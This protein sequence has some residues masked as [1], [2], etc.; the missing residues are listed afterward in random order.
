MQQF[1]SN[2]KLL[3]SGEYLVLDG[4]VSLALP[5]KYGQSLEVNNT[6][7]NT[8]CWKSYT[9][10]KE[11][12]FNAEFNIDDFGIINNSSIK[13]DGNKIAKTLQ[14]ILRTAKL[15]NPYFLKDCKGLEIKTAL[16][17]PN[18]WGLGTSSTLINNIATWANVNAFELLEKSFG[19]SG[20]D[21]ACAQNNHVIT[22]QRNGIQPVVK[23]IDFNPSFKNELFFVYLNQKQDSKEGIKMYRSLSVDKQSY[24]D[25]INSITNKIIASKSIEEFAKLLTEHEIFLGD[26]L[27]V[28]PVKEKLFPDYHGAVKSLGAW[29]GDF[30]LVTGTEKEVKDYFL[31]KNYPTIISYNDMILN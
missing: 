28:K 14:E 22:Y 29:G 11:C 19:G 3:I 4:A 31:S 9:V 7:A 25:E 8:I 16:S 21:I 6:T 5:T 12:W 24:I 15:L 18:Y 27:K 17:F 23:Q 26:I 30:V 20:Y 2:G 1:Y 10:D 13:N